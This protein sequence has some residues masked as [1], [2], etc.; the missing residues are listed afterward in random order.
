MAGIAFNIRKLLHKRDLS[1]AVS[2]FFYSGIISSGPWLFAVFAL[3]VIASLGKTISDPQ[4]VNTFMGIIIYVFALTTVVT[5]GTQIS[6]TRFLSDC[7][8]RKEDERIPS[9][10]LSCL[11]MTG[12]S[13]VILLLPWLW[14]LELEWIHRLLTLYLL[15]LV[16]CM[17]GVMI[18]VS[19]L[20]AY[21]R[22]SLAFLVGFGLAVPASLITGKFFGLTG[23]LLGLNL[24]ISVV[25]FILSATVLA[26]FP[27][28]I[29][30]DFRLFRSFSKYPMLFFYGLLSG[31]GIWVDKFL[32]WLYH[33]APIGAGL[34]GFPL[35]DGAMF[36]G[37]MT[38][39]PALAYFILIAE[40]DLYEIVRKYTYLINHH[41]NLNGLKM[42]RKNL[43]KCMQDVLVKIGVFQGLFSLFMFFTAPFWI[44]SLNLD[45][46]QLSILRFSI[47]GA[48]FH[49]GSMLLT[50]VLTYI[51]GEKDSFWIVLLFLLTNLLVTCLMLG[52]ISFYGLGYLSAAVI[53]FLLGFYLVSFRLK[54]LHYFLIC[55][56]NT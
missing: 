43:I 7:L 35:Y 26:E 47:I 50:I 6:I 34:V 53:S 11:L 45:I 2:A 4:L 52:D 28:D 33:K 51:N 55:E 40:T 20:K 1:S 39:L 44:Q 21:I 36:V 9:L 15:A 14:Y 8:Y 25:V 30:I 16:A 41:G 38:A 46:T 56:P 24:G 23:F 37:Y 54:H 31:L 42:I 5:Y 27:G 18:F 17:W 49:M 48:F 32:I 29:R 13:S 3:G 12:G 10:L 22:V 19:T